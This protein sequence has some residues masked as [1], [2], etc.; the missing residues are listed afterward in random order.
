MAE[1]ITFNVNKLG[2]T[3]RGSARNFD[4]RALA[5]LVN[6]PATQERV[7]NRDMIG[8]Y[9]HFQRMKF[10]LIPPETVI[11]NGKAISIE[12]AIT[13]TYLRAHDDGTIEH[14]TEFLDTA[15]GKVAARLNRS[16]TGGFSTAIHAKERGGRDFATVFAGFDY[17]LEPN[18]TYNR[19]YTFDSVGGS[20]DGDGGD[21]FDCV[22]QDFDQSNTA[23]IA[24][25]DSL[26]ADHGLA[27]ATMQRLQEDNEELLSLLAR[28]GHTVL[29]SVGDGQRPAMLSKQATLAFAARSAQFRGASLA[30]FEPVQD[31]SADPVMAQ[32]LQHWGVKS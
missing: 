9:G 32:A 13:T 25:Y 28:G 11:V 19:G 16:K 24:L 22:M 20:G 4:T 7:K 21:I 10:G 18:V 27:M 14:R 31:E 15:A 3:Y 17:V 12:P 5:A 26:H 29:D 6:S 30:R 2:R 1:I 23:M 8:Y